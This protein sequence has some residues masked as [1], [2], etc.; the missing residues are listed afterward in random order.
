LLGGG[1]CGA[2]DGSGSDDNAG[3]LD[4]EGVGGVVD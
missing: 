3:F 1:N 4:E 2:G